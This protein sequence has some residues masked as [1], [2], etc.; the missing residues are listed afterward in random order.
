MT[1]QPAPSSCPHR[2][3][4]LT[5]S[6]KGVRSCDQMAS[7]PSKLSESQHASPQRFPQYQ[8]IA[9]ILQERFTEELLPWLRANETPQYQLAARGTLQRV[10]QANELV[11]SRLNRNAV[12]QTIRHVRHGMVTTGSPMQKTIPPKFM[13]MRGIEL[14]PPEKRS[15]ELLPNRPCSKGI[16]PVLYLFDIL[17]GCIVEES[18]KL[19]EVCNVPENISLHNRENWI[20]MLE[21]ER[22]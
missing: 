14:S 13:P 15:Q 1:S 4:K 18:I 8:L 12:R 11:S 17:L 5:P 2:G 16:L 3:F 7:Q 20:T 6:R 22:R 19:R 10:W 9:E 21:Q